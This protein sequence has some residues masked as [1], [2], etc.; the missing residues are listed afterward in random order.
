MTSHP[1]NPYIDHTLSYSFFSNIWLEHAQPP[2]VVGVSRSDA[3][4][5]YV[6]AACRLQWLQAAHTDARVTAVKPT[7]RLHRD[8]FFF[9]FSP[10]RVLFSQIGSF[11]LNLEYGPLGWRSHYWHQPN[12]YWRQCNWRI[13]IDDMALRDQTSWHS[14]VAGVGAM[15]LGADPLSSIYWSTFFYSFSLFYSIRPLLGHSPASPAPSS[16]ADRAILRWWGRWHPPPS[17]TRAPQ[18]CTRRWPPSPHRWTR[19]RANTGMAWPWWATTMASHDEGEGRRWRDAERE[20]GG[21][22]EP[23]E[24]RGRRV[25]KGKR[26]LHAGPY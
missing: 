25:R 20:R 16:V 18:P 13:C 1:N 21:H 6:L 12:T 15:D 3:A 11:Y 8:R 14:D 2:L 17:P 26:K 5:F 10:F 19:E 22:V 23:G 9:Y 4:N 7:M 24:R